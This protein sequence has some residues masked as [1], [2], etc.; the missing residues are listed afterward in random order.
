MTADH[1]SRRHVG[2]AGGSPRAGVVDEDVEAAKAR[3]GR[4]HDVVHVRV[5]ANVRVERFDLP[6]PRRLDM[7]ARLRK[8]CLGPAGDRH[9]GAFGDE[10][11][12]DR[13]SD[14]A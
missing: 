6:R 13:E 9:V 2:H 11:A 12:R 8:V 5:L 1:C 4:R 7:A 3:H 10:R 14:T